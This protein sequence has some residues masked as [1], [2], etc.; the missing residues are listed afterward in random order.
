MPPTL[1]TI[2]LSS[3]TGIPDGTIIPTTA[4]TPDVVVKTRSPL[5]R[6]LIRVSRVYVNGLVGMLALV[7]VNPAPAYLTP[8]DEFFGKLVM[9]AGFAVAPAAL[10]LLTNAAEVLSKLDS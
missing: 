3:G 6:T 10:T 4:G 7:A 9:A 1:R 5:V 2:A 8:P